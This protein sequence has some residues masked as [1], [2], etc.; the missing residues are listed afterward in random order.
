MA[1]RRTTARS[2]SCSRT[3]PGII[4]LYYGE[5]RTQTSWE[6]QTD[7]IARTSTAKEVNGATRLYGIVDDGDLAYVEE[8]AMVGQPMQPHTSARLQ[9]VVG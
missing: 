2:S 3:T 5:S 7:A 8:R 1:C 4:E 9:R 6:L